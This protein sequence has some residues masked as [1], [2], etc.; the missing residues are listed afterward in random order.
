MRLVIQFKT[1]NSYSFLSYCQRLL[2]CGGH[3]SSVAFLD[4]KTKYRSPYLLNVSQPY[5]QNH[6]RTSLGRPQ[7]VG[8]TR[9]LELQI[10]PYRDVL[11]TSAED[12]LK[13]L[14]G[15]VPWCHTM[16]TSSGLYIGTSFGTSYF[17]VQRTSLEDALRATEGDV[18]WRYIEGHIRTSIERLL[19]TSSG[20]PRDVILPS[21]NVPK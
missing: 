2:C 1:R 13:T 21:V 6:V 10:R 20:R 8:R 11:V 18:P 15:D 16:R 4:A 12:L 14:A 3:S 7:D 9:P 5:L 19:E 17:N